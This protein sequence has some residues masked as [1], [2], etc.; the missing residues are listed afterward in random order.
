ME[1]AIIRLPEA[2]V[3][4]GSASDLVALAGGELRGED[5]VKAAV[6]RF[7]VSAAADA[8]TDGLRKSIEVTDRSQLGGN[9]AERLDA[10][11]A[12]ADAFAPPTMLSILSGAVNPE[13][14]ASNAN[15][16]FAAAN[17]RAPAAAELRALAARGGL[18]ND[19][20]F[21]ATAT[22]SAALAGVGLIWL[23]VIAR[24]R[25]ARDTG[26]TDDGPGS[27]HPVGSF[28]YAREL[29]DT[30][31]LVQAGRPARGR[32]RGDAG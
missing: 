14:L 28:A 18:S 8:V 6:A 10:F 4:A 5:A 31:E 24:P 27:G 23:L 21:T 29:L 15:R 17:P 30:G 11:K 7:G 26:E 1:A 12:A 22:G 3:Y 2:M 16:V 32:E 25:P 9:I 13:R 19:W 20:R